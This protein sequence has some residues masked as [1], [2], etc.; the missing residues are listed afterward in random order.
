MCS[1][2]KKFIYYYFKKGVMG[3]GNELNL[4]FK[5]LFMLFL[6]ISL[7]FA[8]FNFAK[9]QESVPVDLTNS[10]GSSASSSQTTQTAVKEKT[11]IENEGC[12]EKEYLSNGLS[13][14]GC[15]PVVCGTKGVLYGQFCQ[16]DS[17]DGKSTCKMKDTCADGQK[18]NCGDVRKVNNNLDVIIAEKEKSLVLFFIPDSK[19][20]D[21]VYT[22]EIANP[23]DAPIHDSYFYN[24]ITNQDGSAMLK[25]YV[26]G[27]KLTT[28]S[29]NVKLS[30]DS[31]KP[32]VVKSTTTSDY[33]PDKY[34]DYTFEKVLS[35][36]KNNKHKDFSIIN[37]NDKSSTQINGYL[38]V[39]KGQVFSTEACTEGQCTEDLSNNNIMNNVI[40]NNVVENKVII[41]AELNA[42]FDVPTAPTFESS[43][44]TDTSEL[45]H[46][47]LKDEQ[48]GVAAYTEIKASDV[49]VHDAGV[50][51]T[52][53]IVINNRIYMIN[54]KDILIGGYS[55]SDSLNEL[56]AGKV[57][58]TEVYLG[59]LKDKIAVDNDVNI[60]LPAYMNIFQLKAWFA[61]KKTDGAVDVV[62]T[63]FCKADNFMQGAQLEHVEAYVF[64]KDADGTTK[65]MFPVSLDSSDNYCNMQID[66][67]G[68]DRS[69]FTSLF[70]LEL[71]AVYSYTA[72]EGKKYYQLKAVD[73]FKFWSGSKTP[74]AEQTNIDINANGMSVYTAKGSELGDVLES[75]LFGTSMVVSKVE[76]DKADI[77]VS[78]RTTCDDVCIK[79]GG[80]YYS[81]EIVG[82][83]CTGVGLKG[84]NAELD[85]KYVKGEYMCCFEN[86]EKDKCG[87]AD[88]PPC[89]FGCKAGLS[90]CQS[91]NGMGICKEFCDG[92]SVSQ[93]KIDKDGK[94]GTDTEGTLVNPN[95]GV[96]PGAP[97]T[98]TIESDDGPIVINSIVLD[99]DS[100][101][102]T[103]E[104]DVKAPDKVTKTLKLKIENLNYEDII[105]YADLISVTN[106]NEPLHRLLIASEQ[107][108]TDTNPG[109]GYFDTLVY[110]VDISLASI[111]PGDYKLKVTVEEAGAP[112]RTTERMWYGDSDSKGILRI[113]TK[114]QSA[115]SDAEKKTDGT[116]PAGTT[117]AGTGNS[118]VGSTN[119]NSNNAAE[120]DAAQIDYNIPSL[121]NKVFT[122]AEKLRIEKAMGIFFAEKSKYDSSKQNL[123]KYFNSIIDLFVIAYDYSGNSAQGTKFYENTRDYTQEQKV[124]FVGEFND[125][126]TDLVK[127]YNENLFDDN[128]GA[129]LA[130]A[131]IILPDDAAL[132]DASWWSAV[133]YTAKTLVKSPL[134]SMYTPWNTDANTGIGIDY[135]MKLAIDQFAFNVKNI[136]APLAKRRVELLKTTETEIVAEDKTGD[137]HY[138]STI[139]TRSTTITKEERNPDSAQLYFNHLYYTPAVLRDADN[140]ANIMYANFYCMGSEFIQDWKYYDACKT[141]YVQRVNNYHAYE[142][143]FHGSSTKLDSFFSYEE[144]FLK[145]DVT[146]LDAAA[147]RMH[148]MAIGNIVV[149]LGVGIA[150]G[151]MIVGV[152][153]KIA[154]FSKVLYSGTTAILLTA[155]VAGGGVEIYNHYLCFKKSSM[156]EAKF[157]SRY[158]GAGVDLDATNSILARCGEQTASTIAFF[159]GG[160]A[161]GGKPMMEEVSKSEVYVNNFRKWFGKKLFD[162]PLMKKAAKG[163]SEVIET[164]TRIYSGKTGE[165]RIAGITTE[166]VAGKTVSEINLGYESPAG[167]QMN[168]AFNDM[169]KVTDS[170]ELP[171]Y[172]QNFLSDLYAN[173]KVKLVSYKDMTYL[174][175]KNK[176]VPTR[177]VNKIKLKIKS[178]GLSKEKEAEVIKYLDDEV[179]RTQKEF[180][181][182]IKQYQTTKATNPVE[183]E[184]IIATEEVKITEAQIETGVIDKE[185][186]LNKEK[187]VLKPEKPTVT[188]GSGAKQ[189]IAMEGH[190]EVVQDAVFT[191]TSVN[192]KFVGGVADGVSGAGAKSAQSA[193]IA[194]EGIVNGETKTVGLVEKLD[195]LVGLYGDD[196]AKIYSELDAYAW[197]TLR[198]V[199]AE[200]TD[201]ATTT[202]I[203]SHIT[204][205]HKLITYRIGD[206]EAR[207]IRKSGLFSKKI[208]HVDQIYEPS[209]T[210]VFQGEILNHLLYRSPANTEIQV[211]QPNMPSQ[212]GSHGKMTLSGF[213]SVHELKPGDRIILSSDGFTPTKGSLNND[214]IFDIVSKASSPVEAEQTLVNEALNMIKQTRGRE[215]LGDDLGNLVVFVAN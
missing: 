119:S 1:N 208:Y 25:V 53:N 163:K 62:L 11:S 215:T 77:C 74:P 40:N 173:M 108:G 2:I 44:F 131:S 148:I 128:I 199:I 132:E 23:D 37:K 140:Y 73:D 125:Y 82:S 28:Y 60:R 137:V 8:Q 19:N 124:Q 70:Q 157:K 201:G 97:G 22:T 57:L 20:K 191:K 177:E 87:T 115:Q 190:D 193:K 179:A 164:E 210:P 167:L 145:D 10:Q 93:V 112:T 142:E 81:K 204:N 26:F 15:G 158:M 138:R 6:M 154:Q 80:N 33:I 47:L 27:K 129:A 141:L 130:A 211:Y 106:S 109:F 188:S 43:T 118:P 156:E 117:P 207:I 69:D 48:N 50:G 64:V 114:A 160:F 29:L 75:K 56:P 174:S 14:A 94:I 170:K 98:S 18:I 198:P 76:K 46:G 147:N 113:M 38:A 181:S 187:S 96:T 182:I 197:N 39:L 176:L 180:E 136:Y 24:I 149:T 100:S 155:T 205:D 196:Y 105:L 102:Q 152:I 52:G 127:T 59:P 3:A 143:N 151:S 144:S 195:E 202:V 45:Y 186:P 168:K 161:S 103:I 71:S 78:D 91:E 134:K 135:G 214:Q 153:S 55:S 212:I 9:G 42:D 175:S 17:K 31:S 67:S 72:A 34:K 189:V 110:D 166:T 122:N 171:S 206:A 68:L 101:L 209:N 213:M 5:A 30:S 66:L 88:L 123:D 83:Y 86:S 169:F 90:A 165:E 172:Y 92:G 63:N 162:E 121:A 7:M 35:K 85:P 58:Q 203:V 194:L 54:E 13:V 126:L 139:I 104:P 159:A 4:R 36:D 107:Y 16:C 41:G 146:E 185:K 111:P 99:D 116:T 184:K 120:S 21:D 61:E 89:I 51:V 95:Q 183:A 32:G 178:A 84:T 49:Y 12:Y 79:E 133:K 150:T 200:S 192:G 65:Q